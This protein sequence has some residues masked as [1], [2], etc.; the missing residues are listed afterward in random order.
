VSHFTKCATKITNLVA[1]KQALDELGYKYTSASEEQKVVVRG[2][3]GQTTQ[4]EICINMGKYD[5]GVVQAEDGT[6][7]FVSDWWGVETT[8]G[9]TEAEFSQEVNQ[10]YAYVRVV[11]ACKTAGYNI[12][13]ITTAE[14]G[15]VQ[16]AA[17]KWG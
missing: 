3:Q 1:L 11:E 17:V 9:T 16:L 13:N 5:I 7:E 2:Y 8:Q 10:K 4:A 14:D 6:Y 15:T 12:D